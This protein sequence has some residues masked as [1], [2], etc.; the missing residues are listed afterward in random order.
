MPEDFPPRL[1]RIFAACVLVAIVLAAAMTL[2][3]PV[4]F[5][6][7]NT[8]D[9]LFLIDVAWRLNN[10]AMP[11][12]DFQHF[13]GGLTEQFIAWAMTLFGPSMKALDQGIVLIW[14]VMTIATGAIAFR[15]LDAF[16]FLGMLTIVSATVLSRAALNDNAT[17]TGPVATYGTLYNRFGAA[18]TILVLAYCLVPSRKPL[19]EPIGAIVT[20][21]ALIALTIIKP[22]FAV[23]IPAALV[24]LALQARWAGLGMVILATVI[25]SFLMDPGATRFLGS[26]AYIQNIGGAPVS[27]ID[28]I[29][30]SVKLLLVQPFALVAAL[31]TFAVTIW[32]QD[33]KLWRWP[34]AALLLMGTALAMASTMAKEAAVGQQIVPALVAFTL[35]VLMRLPLTATMAR[36]AVAT[37][38]T[39]GGMAFA[40]P[41]LL[42]TMAAGAMAFQ[43]RDAGL[44]RT[45][46]MAPFVG[47]SYNAPLVDTKTGQTKPLET[48]KEDVAQ[49]LQ[50]GTDIDSG[51][52]TVLIADAVE[53]LAQIKDI[54]QSGII[55][56]VYTFGFAM[57]APPVLEFPTYQRASAPELD[58]ATPFPETID[59]VLLMRHLLPNKS[60][61]RANIVT[62][63]GANFGVCLQS[64]LWLIYS[65]GDRE[66]CIAPPAPDPAAQGNT[67]APQSLEE[68]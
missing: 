46:P 17:L 25:A 49:A 42:N 1:L 28:L 15:R 51:M 31:T 68:E 32:A 2:L 54:S 27:P 19:A 40:G 29:E 18:V 58:P 61:I 57:G 14:V 26:I 9:T 33:D 67:P 22:T 39:V 16:G 38:A 24:A 53:A 64:E 35:F 41:M 8:R 3:A 47:V 43:Q 59:I 23:L 56:E 45:G 13:Y 66:G 63:M 5:T 10:G 21:V 60:K 52:G 6:A 44:V 36:T 65:R 30:K 20:G 55:S 4:A 37:L 11:G 12:V 7:T 34:L 62:K 48:L 50:N